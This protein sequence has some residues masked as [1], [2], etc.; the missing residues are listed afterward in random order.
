MPSRKSLC[1]AA[2]VA[3]STTSVLA[4]PAPAP[5]ALPAAPIQVPATLRKLPGT[6]AQLV[7]PKRANAASNVAIP[8]TEDAGFWFADFSV[9][10]SPSDSM[11]IDTGS[12][13]VYM[14]PGKYQPGSSARDTG[15]PFTISFAT[16][17]SDGSGSETLKGEV[18]TDTVALGGISVAKQQLGNVTQSNVAE[19]FPHDGLVGFA[20]QDG[21]AF[22]GVPWFQSACNDGL[23]SACR[24]G[25]AFKTDGT[26]TQTLGGVDPTYADSLSTVGT[27]DQ[28]VVP[29]DVSGGGTQV[30]NQASAI[31]DSG[32]TV[33]YGPIDSVRDLYDALGLQTTQ[34]SVGG[35][36]YLYATYP[37]GSPPDVTFGLGGGEFKIEDAAW[38]ASQDGSTCTATLQGTDGFG[39]QWLVGQAFFQGKYVDH[40][41]DGAAM[42]FANL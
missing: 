36:N 18:W 31:F 41:I 17:N 5:A 42:G 19:P 32:T 3:A 34:K 4:A 7:R 33:V 38:P 21:S 29:L 24:F 37:C 40:D 39:D 12:S 8:E 13:D 27:S 30:A 26:G 11:L 15:R 9:G 2:V 20:G 23:V 10:A 35:Q 6:L 25:L 1:A 22:G 14:N 16:T 28:W